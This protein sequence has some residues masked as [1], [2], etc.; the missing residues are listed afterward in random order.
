MT[1]RTKLIAATFTPL[2][3]AGKLALP[4]IDDH[5]HY[6]QRQGAV[7]GVFICGTTGEGVSLTTPERQQ[8]AEKWVEVAGDK[9]P[10]IVHVGHTSVEE[11]RALADHAQ[12]IGAAGV[13]AIG[14]FFFRP[15]T[16][17]DLVD[18]C[19]V[20]AAGCPKVRFYYYHIPVLT[21]VNLSMP[22]FLRQATE[23]IPNFAGI[24][25]TDADLMDLALCRDAA[26]PDQEI[27]FGWDEVMLSGL[28]FGC[29]GFV[30]ST[31][32]Y[33]AP[34]YRGLIDAFHRGDLEEA[35]R[36]QRISQEIVLILKEYG[37]LPG[38]KAMMS[39]AGVDHGPPR[40]P[41]RG[42]SEEGKKRMAEALKPTGFFDYAGPKGAAV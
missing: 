24:K 19:A 10:V 38:G 34:L 33:I 35:R 5:F 42:V 29:A 14:P 2:T 27:F 11:S 4:Q 41:L 16:V 6:L 18:F 1:T 15:K 13:A 31:Y 21:G 26:T 17:T 12:S 8:V 20:I 32:S 28:T 37:G 25:Y 30:G 36:A 9:L 7:D 23:R 40:L 22:A 39:L 3:G